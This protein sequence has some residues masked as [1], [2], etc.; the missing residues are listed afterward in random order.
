MIKRFND[1]KELKY[2]YNLPY[3]EIYLACSNSNTDEEIENKL[4]NIKEKFDYSSLDLERESKI[5]RIIE[6]IEGTFDFRI[7]D[8]CLDKF[9]K[10]TVVEDKPY[11]IIGLIES[12]YDIYWICVNKNNYKKFAFLPCYMS[13]DDY[14]C[15]KK[16]SKEEAIKIFNNLDKT[17]NKD[18]ERIIY[19]CLID[20]IYD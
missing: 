14:E 9:P 7:A 1:I 6:L 19:N 16:F 11:C 20:K 10:W 8:D 4:N 15:D 17:L 12:Y 13:I 5:N 3:I 18:K 2:K